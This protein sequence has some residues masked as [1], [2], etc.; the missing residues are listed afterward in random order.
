[1]KPLL[2]WM[3]VALT[4]DA[5][6][7]DAPGESEV[8]FGADTEVLPNTSGRALQTLKHRVLLKDF[9]HWAPGRVPGD[10]MEIVLETMAR[11]DEQ[12]RG[13]PEPSKQLTRH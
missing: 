1:M 7:V 2:D 12:N 5:D 3:W 13:A 10:R 4:H 6:E 9:P 11:V 8:L